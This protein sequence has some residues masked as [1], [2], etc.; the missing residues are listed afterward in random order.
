MSSVTSGQASQSAPPRFYAYLLTGVL[1]LYFALRFANLMEIPVFIDEAIH[2]A[3]AKT[4]ATSGPLAVG[5]DGR[6]LAIQ[7]MSLFVRLPLEPL[8]AV[9]LSSALAGAAAMLVVVALGRK[10]YGWREAIVAGL[11]FAVLPY[12]VLYTRLG[13]TDPLQCLLVAL[14][15]LTS[16]YYAE[17]DSWINLLLVTVAANLAI[18]A[19]FSSLPFVALPFLV[20]AIMRPVRDWPAGLSKLSLVLV[21]AVVNAYGQYHLGWVPR[22]LRDQVGAVTLQNTARL[23]AR[24]AQDAAEWYWH[25]LTPPV[26]L[27]TFASVVA[28][29]LKRERKSLIPAVIILLNALPFIV[30]AKTW[31]PRYLMVSSIGVALL[32]ARGLVLFAEAVGA[33]LA[34]RGSQAEWTRV[35]LAVVSVLVVVWPLVMAAT[36]ALAPYSVELPEAVSHQYMTGWPSGYGVAEVADWLETEAA[37]Q[38]DGIYVVRF[39]YWDHPLF[40]LDL[41]LTGSDRLVVTEVTANDPETLTELRELSVERPTYFV[42]NPRENLPNDHFEQLHSELQMELVWNEVRPGGTLGLEVWRVVS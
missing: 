19:K 14:I 29:A 12:T 4:V 21:S 9:R 17:T 33:R 42:Y 11:V 23:L 25:L 10:L 18:L 28:V 7:V 1:A 2:I 40:G 34:K 36:L 24:N 16:V 15:A 22:V 41:Y 38:P 8:L 37:V 26:V 20:F 6:W 35:P 5:T 31:F 13:L 3:W 27:T 32:V 39:D 30:A